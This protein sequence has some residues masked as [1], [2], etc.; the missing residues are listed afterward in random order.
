MESS[1]ECPT[2]GP[3]E[4]PSRSEVRLWERCA[5]SEWP[6]PLERQSRVVAVLLDLVDPPDGIAASPRL[7]VAA[8]KALAAFAGLALQQ[9]RVDLRLPQPPDPSVVDVREALLA[10]AESRVESRVEAKA[11]E[12]LGRRPQLEPPS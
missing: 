10:E 1:R 8:S 4:R 5:R 9:Q 7:Q 12:L 2:P 3:S 6:I 11:R